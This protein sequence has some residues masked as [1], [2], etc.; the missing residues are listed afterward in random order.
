MIKKIKR[1]FCIDWNP[2]LLRPKLI[3]SDYK[4]VKRT[5]VLDKLLMDLTNED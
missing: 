3:L 5:I 4:K 1:K 2:F